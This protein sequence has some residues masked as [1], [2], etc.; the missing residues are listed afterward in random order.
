MQTE[1]KRISKQRMS[2]LH[3]DGAAEVHGLGIPNLHLARCKNEGNNPARDSTARQ[4][5]GSAIHA[6]SS[7]QESAFRGRIAEPDSHDSHASS[8]HSANAPLKGRSATAST[9]SMWPGKGSSTCHMVTSS[10]RESTKHA[11]S[12]QQNNNHTDCFGARGSIGRYKLRG[13]WG[14]CVKARAHA[15]CDDLVYLQ[16]CRGGVGGVG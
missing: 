5:P 11:T 2:W 13:E 3:L 12:L 8:V 4:G 16:V 15:A 10:F 9:E 7:Q 1:R 6:S 14:C